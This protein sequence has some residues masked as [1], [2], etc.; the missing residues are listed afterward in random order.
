MIPGKEAALQLSGPIPARKFR[1]SRV[2][3]QMVL[4]S[5]L[6]ESRIVEGAKFRGRTH[7]GSE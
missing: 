5:K 6:I 7:E 1:Q 3:C 2:T 4:E